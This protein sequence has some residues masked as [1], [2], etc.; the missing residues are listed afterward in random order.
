[1]NI[2]LLLNPHRLIHDYRMNVIPLLTSIW[3][4]RHLAMLLSLLALAALC[5]VG[6]RRKLKGA[7]YSRYSNESRTSSQSSPKREGRNKASP[8]HKETSPLR[9]IGCSPESSDEG[10]HFSG[11]TRTL[12]EGV[13]TNREPHPS[14]SHPNT[15]PHP[16]HVLLVS[17]VLLIIPF[18]PASNLFYPVGF[19]VAERILY[20]PSM[21]FCMLVGYSAHKMADSKNR[22][23]ST[24]V[25]AALFCLIS[26]H[27]AKTVVRNGD[28]QSK[29]R[30]YSSLARHYP[31]NGHMLVNIAREYR[32][33]GDLER[34]ELAY[35]HAMTVAPDLPSPRVN[36]GS[37]LKNLYRLEEAEKVSEPQS[38]T[39]LPHCAIVPWPVTYFNQLVLE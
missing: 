32:D 13:R 24:F 39:H 19:V 12:K 30:L 9:T 31:G 37:M 38:A 16:S 3:D 22:L 36:L 25:R 17:L 27:A 18:I 14:H 23:V 35:R 34:A 11:G 26:T 15:K 10:S 29:L 4:P 21:G 20:L 28:W 8:G 6:L 7:W 5:G 1:M 33:T 2:W